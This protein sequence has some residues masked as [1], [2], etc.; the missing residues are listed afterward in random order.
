MSRSYFYQRR[1]IRIPAI[2]VETAEEDIRMDSSLIDG[3][4]DTQVVIR[5]PLTYFI[6]SLQHILDS[7]KT[8]FEAG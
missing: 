3:R 4:D 5:F 8:L 1:S 2:F 6:V 7:P